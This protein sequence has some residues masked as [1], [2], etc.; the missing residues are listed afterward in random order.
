[1]F[2]AFDVLQSTQ[3]TF[4]YKVNQYKVVAEYFLY[5]V[6]TGFAWFAWNACPVARA[7]NALPKYRGQD[8]GRICLSVTRESL[9]E[10]IENSMLISVITFF[11]SQDGS[12]LNDHMIKK[13]QTQPI[14][15]S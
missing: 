6:V 3:Q 2:L 11:G 8:L 10:P 12:S 7:K 15:I 14:F 13:N 1:M 5:Y 4:L 9:V